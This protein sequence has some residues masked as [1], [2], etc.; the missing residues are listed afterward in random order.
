MI[1]I[2][3]LERD[4]KHGLYC[5]NTAVEN[6][7]HI[8]IGSTDVIS[9]RDT[10]KVKCYP[11]TS[12]NDYVPFYFSVRTPMLFNI[13]SGYGG[14]KI[15]PQKDIIYLCFKLSDLATHEHRW[16][17]TDGNASMAFTKFYNDL[18]DLDKID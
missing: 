13:K 1:H 14:I 5:R 2:Q 16:C 6:P 15:F 10:K 18:A 12:V 8:S 7:H 9:R 4:I 17:Y 3:N 11:E